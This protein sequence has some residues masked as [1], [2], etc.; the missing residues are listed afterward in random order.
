[1]LLKEGINL[2][3]VGA[4]NEALKFFDEYIK[5]GVRQKVVYF[6]RGMAHYKFGNFC[7]AK[8]DLQTFIGFEP[9]FKDVYIPLC[10][11]IF[12]CNDCEDVKNYS[13]TFYKAISFFP[14]NAELY[15]MALKLYGYSFN[16]EFYIWRC[17]YDFRSNINKC[18]N[19]IS[20]AIELDNCNPIYYK[21]RGKFYGEVNKFSEALNDFL[22][23]EKYCNKN[24]N[25]D[26]LYLI[27]CH[28][29][30]CE[31]PSKNFLL[32]KKYYS[33]INGDKWVI[34]WQFKRQTVDILK[35]KIFQKNVTKW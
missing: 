16:E 4:Y 21:T 25:L 3:N 17:K 35:R 19:L 2:Y 12:R 33:K 20:K 10:T 29:C 5:I 30:L 22:M 15:Y 18:L 32:F 26:K 11:S 27:I 14:H 34:D 24:V 28:Y 7:Y 8:C 1:M 31:K 13:K 9:N 6:Y 23:F